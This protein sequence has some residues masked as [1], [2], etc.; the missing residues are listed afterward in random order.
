MDLSYWIGCTMPPVVE[1]AR[2]LTSLLSLCLIF[3]VAAAAD[4]AFYI[5]LLERGKKSFDSGSYER[6]AKE[7]RIAAFGLL[8]SL[9]SYETA[10]IYLALAQQRLG[11]D[12]EA[13]IAIRRLLEAERIVPAYQVLPIEASVRQAFESLARTVLRPEE[14]AALTEI[15]PSERIV[16]TEARPQPP[17]PRP[18][19]AAPAAAPR[20][21]LAAADEALRRGDL[22]R[23]HDIYSQL[24]H[25]DIT[26]R[27]TLLQV[28]R[29]LYQTEDFLG[30]VQ[31]FSR[32]GS[33][34]PGEEQYHYYAAVAL[35]ETG[36]FTAAK[37]QLACALPYIE[38]TD[39]V[40][41]YEAKI[42]AAV[43]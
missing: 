23:A 21:E 43:D 39:D 32:I 26:D 7:L 36:Y 15:G 9:A 5:D 12:A 2:K 35:F 1:M 16:T 34:R 11:N 13:A 31:A 29:G 25:S 37:R 22:E 41:R 17:P 6:A 42:E 19:R 10:L 40:A 33:L 18:R 4:V 24:L 3:T 14:L 20:G 28:A 30:A 27:E 38:V 8:D